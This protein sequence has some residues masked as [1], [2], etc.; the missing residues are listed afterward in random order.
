MII[1]IR[2]D[3]AYAEL[4]LF[5]TTGNEIANKKW[6]AGFELSGQILTEAKSLL[7]KHKKDFIDISGVI[8]YKG[9]G[10]F[11]ALRIG[12]SVGNALAYANNVPVVGANGSNWLKD[13]L[14]TLSKAKTG[15]YIV[16]EY[17]A[18]PHITKPKK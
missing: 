13:G 17:G 3:G 8:L 4:Y 11:T 18:P 15:K 14:K 16:P 1:A 12:I 9:P 5:D 10:S 6:D 2:T 7:T